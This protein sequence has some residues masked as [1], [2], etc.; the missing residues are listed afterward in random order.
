MPPSVTASERTSKYRHALGMKVVNPKY[1][2]P[3][4]GA[5]LKKNRVYENPGAVPMLA[6]VRQKDSGIG[7][8][9]QDEIDEDCEDQPAF[10]EE[11]SVQE[12]ENKD[13][14]VY[15]SFVTSQRLS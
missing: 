15:D 3:G 11:I 14:D 10:F 6:A 2:L 8:F 5:R 4:V 1:H 12:K 7:E 9:N 13:Y